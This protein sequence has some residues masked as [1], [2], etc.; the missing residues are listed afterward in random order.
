MSVVPASLG[1][2]GQHPLFAVQRFFMPKPEWWKYR[3][4]SMIQCRHPLHNQSNP[5]VKE[6]ELVKRGGVWGCR[7]C[8]AKQKAISREERMAKDVEKKKKAAMRAIR[9]DRGAPAMSE[10]AVRALRAFGGVEGYFGLMRKEFDAADEGSTT[11]KQILEMVGRFVMTNALSGGV[12]SDDDLSDEELSAELEEE[13]RSM[14]DE[15]EP[16][17]SDEYVDE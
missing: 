11:R 8:F 13:L 1:A 15:D 4:R 16:D 17:D 2:A 14:P 7:E 3:K 10:A 5:F 6:G 12:E 9:E